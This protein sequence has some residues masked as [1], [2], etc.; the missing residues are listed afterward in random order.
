MQATNRKDLRTGEF[1]PLTIGP[2]RRVR[3]LPR[4]KFLLL[5]FLGLALLLAGSSGCAPSNGNSS[6]SVTND[7]PELT[8]EIIR[9]RINDAA[10]WDVPEANGAAEPIGWRF[11]EDEPKEITVVEKQMEGT[12]ATIVLDIKTRTA[13]N[14]R[15][16]RELAGQIR[17][18]WE[19]KTG[20]ALRRWEIVEIENISMK[21]KDL[22]KPSAQNSNR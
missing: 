3:N 22:P 17:T 12:R 8:E 7:L 10:I 9:E 2:V 11:G 1:L 20:W 21:Y 5:S 19:L 4:T 15:N 6:D 13:P 14:R 18:K 16:L